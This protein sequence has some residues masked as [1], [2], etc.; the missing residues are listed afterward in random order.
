VLGKTKSSSFDTWL[1]VVLGSIFLVFFLS[2]LAT[3][4]N[5]GYTN[6]NHKNLTIQIS[7]E[8]IIISKG[9]FED[10]MVL[11]E[12]DCMQIIKTHSHDVY[13]T[14]CEYIALKDERKEA[15][16]INAINSWDD[17]NRVSKIAFLFLFT[18]FITLTF[19]SINHRNLNDYIFDCK[20][21]NH[22]KGINEFIPQDDK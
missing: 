17:L 12:N 9:L 16:L 20:K 13:R 7:R 22:L 3:F 14:T 19:G 6:Y 1:L 4:P 2:L 18:F 5:K 10:S 8:D 11:N 15:D 21:N